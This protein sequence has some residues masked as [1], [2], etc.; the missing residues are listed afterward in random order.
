MRWRV[1]I[2]VSL[3]VNVA[4]ALGWFA[5]AR[6]SDTALG[7]TA[8]AETSSPK[9][10][11]VVR[12]QFFSWDQVESSDYPTYITNLRAI[13]CP[14]QTIRDIIIAEINALYSRRL[15]T[16]LTTP[17]QQWWRS[18]PD[19]NVVRAA[20][21]KAREL[22]DERRTLLARLLG[23][24]WESGDLI[25]LPR[26]SRPAIKLDGPVL[27]FLPNEVKEAIESISV[28][29]Q[30]RLQ[31]YLREAGNRPD[32]AQLAKLRQQ[33]RDELA[34]VLTPPQLEEYLLRYSQ[35][36]NN[37][38]TELGQLRYFDATPDEFRAVFRAT[39]SIDQ[40]LQLL[41]ASTNPND[42]F[43]RR[44]LEQQRENALKL[45]LGAQRYQQYTAL[46]DP[47]YR[48]AVAD[49]L[50]A[51][52]PEAADTI[53]QINLATAQQQAAIRANTNFTAAQRAIE[54]KRAELEQLKARAQAMGQEVTPEQPPIPPVMNVQLPEASPTRMHAYVFAIGDTVASVALRYGVSMDELRAANPGVDIRRVK[55][56]DAIQV[57]DSLTR[58]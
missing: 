6:R 50:Q 10:N 24:N 22:D 52:T 49:A 43:Q 37:L 30:E 44:A 16:E 18:E 8:L 12:R 29:S 51:G 4:L 27:G 45:A 21:A 41:A 3:V 53:Y 14:E 32:P 26:P 42:A 33:S 47:A 54:L 57:P 55:P 40:Q 2:V 25:N 19:T 13:A 17:E 39:D 36:A 11:V 34:G 35:N 15:A 9:T 46:H 38:R 48:D 7:A 1:L 58:R 56:G 23:P 28:R 5:S 31:A 20:T